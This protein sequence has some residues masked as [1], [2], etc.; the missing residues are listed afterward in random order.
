MINVTKTYLPP[1]EEYTEYLK[2]V[3]DRNWVTNQGP[4]VQELEKQLQEYLG[5]RHL[6]FV[7][8]GTIALQL[9]IKALGLT[10]EIITTPFS[11]VATTTSILWENCKPVFVDIEARTFCI[12]AAKIEAA[13]TEKTSAILATHVYGFPCDVEAI[14]AIAVKYKLKVIYDGAHAFGVKLKGQS[15]FNFGDV[16]TISFH[17]TKLFHT[18]EGG[19]VILRDAELAEK[20]FLHKSFGHRGDDYYCVGINGKSS[21][22]HAAMGLCLLPRIESF[23]E[24]RKALFALYRELLGRNE[25]LALHPPPDGIAYNYAYFPV[26]FSSEEAL[27]ATRA[28]LA[29]NEIN[30]RRYFYPSLN[31][32][33]YHKGE[34]CPVAEDISRRVLCLPFYQE[35]SHE[36]VLRIVR[37][38]NKTVPA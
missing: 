13:I 21:E 17:A 4:V 2:G 24:K 18:I 31:N 11:Y 29:R 30:T 9:A 5:V 10:G 8:N 35:L 28:E 37:L 20:V 33:P 6:Q 14:E 32:L 16:S 12:D 36:D 34:D 19:A 7:G 1:L 23:I 15:I 25:S 26:V 27:L 3:W 22:I 38:V